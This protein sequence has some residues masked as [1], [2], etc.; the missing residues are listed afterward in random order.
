MMTNFDWQGTA[1]RF[2]DAWTSQDVERVLACYADTELA[3]SDPNTRGAI[4]TKDEFRRY[5]TKL[6]AAWSMTWTAREVRPFGDGG[7]AAV[8]WRATFAKAGQ[9]AGSASI[10]IDGIDLVELRGG[11]ITRNEVQFDRAKL[12]QLG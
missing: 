12:A 4:R 2:L 8:L 6:F 5:L 10:P 11:V 7:G 1:T 3:Y 9:G